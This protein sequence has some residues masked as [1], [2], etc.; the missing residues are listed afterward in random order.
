M[1]V[2]D[3]PLRLLVRIKCHCSFELLSSLSIAIRRKTVSCIVTFEMSSSKTLIFLF[4]LTCS[5]VFTGPKNLMIYDEEIDKNLQ[6][7]LKSCW[8]LWLWLL[9]EETNL[10]KLEDAASMQGKD[11][12][13]AQASAI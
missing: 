5:T 10:F 8:W 9:Y 2:C 1:V 13:Q 7:F 4:S 11:L 3:Q 12:L 6:N